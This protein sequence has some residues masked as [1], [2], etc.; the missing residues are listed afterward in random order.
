MANT[1]TASPAPLTVVTL[2][3]EIDMATDD[4][5]GEQ[6][7]AALFPG[8]HVVIADMTATTFCDSLGIRMLLL[9]WRRAAEHGTDLRLLLP[10]PAVLRVLGVLG[11]DAVLPV[12]ST[13]EE[14]RAGAGLR[15]RTLGVWPD[16]GRSLTARQP[17]FAGPS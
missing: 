13:L 17:S 11:V 5:F 9:A 16:Q 4:A 8:V 12:Y 7:A 15:S 6:V 2:P 10:N 14:A 1:A 3:A